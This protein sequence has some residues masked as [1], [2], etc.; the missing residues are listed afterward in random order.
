VELVNHA[1][2]SF[3]GGDRPLVIDPWLS[4]R[5]FDDGWALVAPTGRTL[6]D[7]DPAVIWFSHEHPDH[8]SPADLQQVDP[9]A[10]VGVTV[11][12]RAGA[13]RKMLDYCDGLGYR[14]LD[15]APGET[16]ELVP[17][18]S[19][20][21]GSAGTDS[22]LLVTQDGHRYLDLND[23]QFR[24]PESLAELRRAV[25][26]PVDVLATQFSFA[27]WVG[28]P[29]D[30]VAPAIAQR[31]IDEHVARQIDA[32]RPTTVL[33][34]ASF[35]YF[36]HAENHW[37]NRAFRGVGPA[38]DHVRACGAEP[39]VLAP[40]GRWRPGD[41][42]TCDGALRFWTDAWARALAAPPVVAPPCNQA[43]LQAALDSMLARLERDND[44]AL[45]ATEIDLEPTWIRVT[46][47]GVRL[48]LDVLGASQFMPSGDEW[49]VSLSAAALAAVLKNPWG[50]GTLTIN[51]RFTANYATLARFFAQ[52]QLFY[53]NNIGRTFPASVRA[54]DLRHIDSFPL[55]LIDEV[56]RAPGSPAAPS[57]R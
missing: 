51:G 56:L 19:A 35:V 14:T 39:L 24:T 55:R 16:Y 41:P 11:A 23:C 9:A 46:D 5:A 52:T 48:R 8:F 31:W 34:C 3:G 40:G 54:E 15:L 27:N 38:M 33:L 25:G 2:L 7:L 29:G 42:V 10:R 6:A 17:G 53:L 21:C 1:C 12:A 4:G 20:Q 32:V 45:L 30:E 43:D 57:P 44:L 37:M 49:D 13:D 47:L 22:W 26:G 28:N 18:I 36:C 50:R